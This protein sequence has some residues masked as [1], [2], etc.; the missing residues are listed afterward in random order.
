MGEYFSGEHWSREKER[1]KKIKY[2]VC[3]NPVFFPKK[4]DKPGF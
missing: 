1:K 2:K 3:N 4:G